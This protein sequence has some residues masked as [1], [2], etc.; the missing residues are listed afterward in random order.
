M[1]YASQTTPPC[2]SSGV[3]PSCNPDTHTHTHTHTHSRS[4]YTQQCGFKRAL[5]L[6][7]HAAARP[8]PLCVCITTHT[9]TNTHTSSSCMHKTDP[10]SS[11]W[12]DRARRVWVLVCLRVWL[13]QGF[14][15]YLSGY[16]PT[17]PPN[18]IPET[19][20][21]LA[22]HPTAHLWVSWSATKG[23][24]GVRNG[25]KWQTRRRAMAGHGRAMAPGIVN[26]ERCSAAA[27]A[28]ALRL[29]CM[30]AP[31]RASRLSLPPPGDARANWRTTR[32][33]RF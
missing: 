3:E 26:K 9:N 17:R 24:S 10:S 27:L 5:G 33:G 4:E 7:W 18:L 23:I 29:Y 6:P 15:L 2:F 19:S 11:P 1:R 22:L 25:R 8:P 31:P 28:D 20:L 13:V 14:H 12:R 21:L 32:C 30:S 16:P